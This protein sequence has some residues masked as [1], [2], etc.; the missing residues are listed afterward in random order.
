MNATGYELN[1][2]LCLYSYIEGARQGV[3]SA[4]FRCRNFWDVDLQSADVIVFFGIPE[5]MPRSVAQLSFRLLL[6]HIPAWFCSLQEKMLDEMSDSALAI[7]HKFPVTDWVP[8][9]MVAH[10][11]NEEEELTTGR[12]YLYD[13]GMERRRQHRKQEDPEHR[14]GSVSH[15]T[16]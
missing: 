12:L 10:E 9:A 1:P 15:H 5:I 4:R 14:G 3:F 16:E 11:S 6:A 7:S 13:V 2:L 8:V